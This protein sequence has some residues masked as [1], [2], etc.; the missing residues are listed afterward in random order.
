MIKTYSDSKISKKI[1]MIS[2]ERFDQLLYFHHIKFNGIAV[3]SCSTKEII[4]RELILKDINI[5]LEKE[6]S[7]ISTL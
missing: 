5:D 1:K 7:I 6:D 3:L 4:Y 2:L